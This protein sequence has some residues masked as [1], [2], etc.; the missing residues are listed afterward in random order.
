MA[1]LLQK[2]LST[3]KWSFQREKSFLSSEPKL[4]AFLSG[5]I[6]AIAST[7]L[8]SS[9]TNNPLDGFDFHYAD[10][11]LLT[12]LFSGWRLKLLQRPSKGLIL[13]SILVAFSFTS[14]LSWYIGIK[15]IVVILTLSSL[16]K[17][18][19]TNKSQFFFPIIVVIA[20]GALVS[21]TYQFGVL[22]V[23]RAWGLS[24]NPNLAA[25]QSTYLILS[26]NPI[27]AA[28]AV[29]MLSATG[30]RGALIAVLVGLV[31][32]FFQ[33]Q[34]RDSLRKLLAIVITVLL[35]SATYGSYFYRYEDFTGKLKGTE[36]AEEQSIS[37][38]LGTEERGQIFSDTIE[39]IRLLPNGFDSRT[40]KALENPHNI[41]LILLDNLGL[42]LG[43][44]AIAILLWKGWTGRYAPYLAILVIGLVDH[45]WITTAQ[46][47]YFLGAGLAFSDAKQTT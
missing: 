7:T 14:L 25:G 27:L 3:L 42:V 1:Q 41:Y 30:S 40:Q 37:R 13:F 18:L 16:R 46:G 33:G 45:Y 38:V 4:V 28:P 23:P 20:V 34:R 17:T 15:F 11:L 12:L 6:V 32:L 19:V 35:I 36:V 10:I 22:E 24:G 9:I 29:I 31:V 43:A 47:I 5:L 26:L 2:Q 39:R 21:L 8:V 44:G